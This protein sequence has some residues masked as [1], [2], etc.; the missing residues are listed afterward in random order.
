MN[1]SSGLRITAGGGSDGRCHPCLRTNLSPMSPTAQAPSCAY[2]RR[3][4]DDG[5]APTISRQE[6]AMRFYTGT[7]KHYCGIDL[8][9]RTMYVCVL[10]QQGV[11]LLHRNL[12][13]NPEIFLVAIA[14]FRED[15]VVAVE[16]VFSWYWVAD[17]C[18]KEE[19]LSCSVTPC[20]CAPYMARRPRS[21][22]SPR[23]RR[24]G[25]SEEECSP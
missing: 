21:T 11:V 6:E 16:C 9:A 4:G 1:G 25:S 8:H 20:T 2:P 7:H 14:P 17:L 24:R 12:P 22:A 5:A 10:S 23:T 3:V 15:L 19:S 18:A 13:S